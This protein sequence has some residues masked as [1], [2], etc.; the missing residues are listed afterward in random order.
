MM[1]FHVEALACGAR[2]LGGGEA[3]GIRAGAFLYIHALVFV[4]EVLV[5]SVGGIALPS[6]LGSSRS[7]GVASESSH[8]TWLCISLV[9][10]VTGRRLH[11]CHVEPHFCHVCSAHMCESAHIVRA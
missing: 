7:L 5:G 10:G 6:S 9:Y 4:Q 3:E 1:V 8:H 2:L 11:P